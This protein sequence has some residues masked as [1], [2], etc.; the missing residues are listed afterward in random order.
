[1]CRDIFRI[2]FQRFFKVLNCTF[3][4]V[5]FIFFYA[6]FFIKV[7][8]IYPKRDVNNDRVILRNQLEELLQKGEI[9]ALAIRTLPNDELKLKTNYSGSNPPY[10]H[11]EAIT[12]MVESGIKHL[13]IDLPSVDREEDGGNLLAHNAFWQYPDNVRKNCTISEL[14]FI[15]NGIKDGLYLLNLQVASFEIDVSPSKPVLYDLK[16][17]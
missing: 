12:Y 13:L 6:T 5:F 2:Y 4:F 14:I 3:V 10:V 8:S 17:I 16:K 9:E 1:M 7:V 11:H 15:P